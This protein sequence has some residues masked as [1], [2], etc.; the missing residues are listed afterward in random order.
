[1][2]KVAYY[3]EMILNDVLEKEA[4]YALNTG[5]GA[6]AGAAGGAAGAAIR[7]KIDSKKK[8]ET[9][10]EAKKRMKQYLTANALFGAATGAGMGAGMTFV[11]NRN[12]NRA[13]R[14]FAINLQN[15]RENGYFKYFK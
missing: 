3:E 4:G 13:R 2:D 11:E 6:L 8:G 12:F 9:K 14:D 5:A 15:L 10:E 1:M 7:A